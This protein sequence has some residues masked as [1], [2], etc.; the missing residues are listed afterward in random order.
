MPYEKGSTPEQLQDKGIPRAFIDQFIEVFN[1]VHAKTGSESEAHSQA[2]GVMAKALHKAGYRQGKDQ[3][4]HPITPRKEEQALAFVP[5]FPSRH[6]VAEE[7]DRAEALEEG[8]RFEGVALIDHAVS[9][10][11]TGFERYYSPAFNDLCLARTQEYMS[12]G[13]VVTLYNTHGAA[14]GGLFA[15]TDK[16][17]IGK[18]EDIR[19][20]GDHIVYQGFIS[21]TDEGKDVIRLMLDG[22]RNETSVRIYDAI[23]EQK[24]LESDTEYPDTLA[25]MREGYIGGIDFCDEAGIP[26][27]GIVQVFESAPRFHESQ[28]DIMELTMDVLKEEHA[29]LVQEIV[30]EAQAPLADRIAEL[31]E[32]INTLRETAEGKEALEANVTTLTEQVAQLEREVAV[33]RAAQGPLQR[34]VVRRLTEENP[35]NLA[36]RAKELR[37]EALG[38]ILAETHEDSTKGQTRF[39]DEDDVEPDEDEPLFEN[40]TVAD[41]MFQAAHLM[42]RM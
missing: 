8:L 23:S 10:Q 15:G 5:F 17:P 2:Y 27:A 41:I 4:W 40:Q 32:E 11:G 35:E 39:K 24:E 13:H 6:V 38:E 22:I 1:S 20:E 29:D 21:A 26:G 34:E 3:K 42:E 31:Q 37:D 28:E 14:L 9:Q 25:V 12:Q 19:R 33:E 7:K 16:N 30:A 36:E 18:V